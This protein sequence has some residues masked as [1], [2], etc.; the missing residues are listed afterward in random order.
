MK[1]ENKNGSS[2]IWARVSLETGEQ[3][4]HVAKKF[5]FRSQY[6]VVQ[7][8]TKSF[9]RVADI[10]NADKDESLP[11]KEAESIFSDLDNSEKDYST[12]KPVRPIGLTREERKANP[13]HSPKVQANLTPKLRIRFDRIVKR[14]GFV[15]NYE[16]LQYAIACFIRAFDTVP[17]RAERD[18]EIEDTFDTYEHAESHFQYVKPK[19]NMANASLND[20]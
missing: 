12:V 13:I 11:P 16:A 20:M 6:Q 9:I 18:T 8:I 2:K 15:S 1:T 4:H 5:G 14:Y 19:R 3:L 7:H 17:K 10:E